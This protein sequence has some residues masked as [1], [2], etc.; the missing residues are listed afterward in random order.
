MLICEWY[1]ELYIE[2]YKK[3]QLLQILNAM[4][5]YIFS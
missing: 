3:T 1:I 4:R 2:L 5:L